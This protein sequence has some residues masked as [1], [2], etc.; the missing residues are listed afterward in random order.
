MSATPGHRQIFFDTETTGLQLRAGHRVIEFAGIEVIDGTPTGKVFHSFFNPDR[1]VEPDATSV[2]GMTW[3][4][5]R[6]KPRFREVAPQLLAFI[7][8]AELIAHNADF[9]AQMM[10]GE[11]DIIKHPRSFWEIVSKLTDTQMLA[12]RLLRKELSR[13]KLSPHLT[14]FFGI[15]A[16]MRTHHNALLDCQLLYQVYVRLIERVDTSRPS[17]EEDVA[18]PPVQY[19]QRAAG[20][21]L[22]LVE[23]M[24][25]ETQANQAYLKQL[26]EEYK[27]EPV[28]LRSPAASVPAPARPKF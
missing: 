24:P 25:Q 2:N 17:L 22:A 11:L 23:V 6:D 5:L 3:D 14:D 26:A 28:A 8:G 10:Q 19:L 12:R 13:F 20:Q 4:M 27:I 1:E 15:D 16:S 7:D 9:D 18:R 21:R